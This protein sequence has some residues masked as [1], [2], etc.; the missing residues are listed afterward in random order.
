MKYYLLEYQINNNGQPFDT[1]F[2]LVLATSYD[3]ALKIACNWCNESHTGRWLIEVTEA[4][5]L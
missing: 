3:E 2:R 5:E 4:L 1:K